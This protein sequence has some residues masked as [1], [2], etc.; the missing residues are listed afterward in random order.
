MPYPCTEA[1]HRCDR[2]DA[3][4]HLPV[5]CPLA[6]I[7][8]LHIAEFFQ[9][10]EVNNIQ[11]V[12]M[13]AAKE[14]MELI[15]TLGDVDMVLEIISTRAMPASVTKAGH[16]QPSFELP[17]SSLRGLPSTNGVTI[18]GVGRGVQPGSSHHSND[19][20]EPESF[21]SLGLPFTDGMASGGVDRGVQTS[22]QNDKIAREPPSF[23]SLGLP[24]T[25]RM[26]FGGV[27]RGVQKGSQIDNKGREPSSPGISLFVPEHTEVNN[28][29]IYANMHDRFRRGDLAASGPSTAAGMLR[30]DQP[31]PSVTD[32]TTNDANL[33]TSSN[34]V[35]ST[36]DASHGISNNI[37]DCTGLF[38][39]GMHAPLAR[40]ALAM[41]TDPVQ[42]TEYSD[43]ALMANKCRNGNLWCDICKKN[44][45]L[46]YH[47][48]PLS[49][50]NSF[51]KT[52][53]NPVESGVP[54]MQNT[55]A[56]TTS[57]PMAPQQAVMST[58]CAWPQPQP[59]PQL[60]P[61][62][63]YNDRGVDAVL[64][65]RF[66][67]EGRKQDGMAGVAEQSGP[68]QGGMA[69]VGGRSGKKRVVAGADASLYRLLAPKGQTQG[70][71]TGVGMQ[72]GPKRVVAGPDE[73]E[74]ASEKVNVGSKKRKY[75][76]MQVESL[77]V[78]L[79]VTRRPGWSD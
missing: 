77:I 74:V 65:Q 34:V 12:R 13:A 29:G 17:S 31:L 5:F 14:T 2:C 39:N 18:S 64:Q 50:R 62:F 23:S 76:Q 22:S 43:S 41:Q 25:D 4:G 51:S 71:M 60:L 6:A 44:G 66:A 7:P 57:T 8:R 52:F 9:N 48:F 56:G 32:F 30:S 68:K 69:G 33:G 27:G 63:V 38:D 3:H 15:K 73:G 79:P 72:S 20:R 40:N 37:T 46:C 1:L 55:F 67:G 24:S 49:F 53:S 70:A 26:T 10:R 42:A 47:L 78:K 45:S 28:N 35:D 61:G 59:Q 58:P 19:G 54:G 16:V 36:K 21:S 75:G 11:G